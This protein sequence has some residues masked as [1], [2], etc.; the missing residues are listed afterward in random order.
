MSRNI[1]VVKNP[2]NPETP[3][4]L[5]SSLIKIADAFEAILNQNRQGLTLGAIVVLLSEMPGMKST[6][7][8]KEI[9]LVLDNLTRLK[10]YY[11]RN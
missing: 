6:V 2:E 7:G 4:V 9:R 5:A 11:V 1:R 10:S 3:E 8:K